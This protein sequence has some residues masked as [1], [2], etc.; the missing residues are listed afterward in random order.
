MAFKMK[1]SPMYRNFGVGSPIQQKRCL[2]G[3][4]GSCRLNLWDRIKSNRGWKKF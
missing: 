4:K 3:F 1:G 2:E